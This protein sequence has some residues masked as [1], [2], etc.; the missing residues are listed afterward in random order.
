MSEPLSH[1]RNLVQLCRFRATD[2]PEWAQH[3]YLRDGEAVARVLTCAQ[4]DRAARALAVQLAR[5]VRPG[6]RAL[7]HYPP[8]LDFVIAFFGC[9]YAGVIAVPTAPVE[10][11]QRAAAARARAVVRSATPELLLSTNDFLAGNTDGLEVAAGAPLTRMAT[12]EVD[13][14]AAED[15]SAPSIEADTIAYLQYSSGSTGEPK[16]VVLTHGQVLHNLSVIVGLLRPRPADTRLVSWLPMFHDMGL[17]SGGL[18]PVYYGGRATLLAPATFIRRPHRWLAA[19][20]HDHVGELLGIARPAEAD[21]VISVVPNFAL[22]LC[23]RRVDE[24]R[25]AG[26]DL[27]PLRQLIIGAEQVRPHTLERFTAAF[28]PCGLRTEALQPCYGLAEATLLV[29]GGPAGEPPHVTEF[30]E[31]AARP[32]VGCG[33]VRP[34]LRVLIADPESLRPRAP[35]EVGE[36]LVSGPSVASGYWNAP[37]ATAG[38]FDAVPP[39]ETES[40]LRTGDLGTFVA[41]QL[42]VTGRRKDLIVIDGVNHYP[43]DLETTVEQAEP[44]VRAG[45]CAVVSVDDGGRELVVV[46]AELA[47]RE[48]ATVDD[49]VAAVRRALSARHGI[50]VHEVLL[51]RPG[52]LPFTSSGKLRRAECRAGYQDGR[53]ERCRVAP[54]GR[55]DDPAGG[56]RAAEVVRP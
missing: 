16:G 11:G 41:G 34:G 17:I 52:S 47:Q 27:R 55:G 21:D 46:L 32:L 49:P 5:R 48:E 35:G 10:G 1:I 29:S 13:P 8:G 54:P 51:L 37:A 42:F 43:A 45:R 4:L 19:I 33:E 12:D 39:G 28:G 50:A 14:A 56:R 31:P 26:L 44:A 3:A 9:L 40:F 7:L 22:E 20:G 25:R 53:F 2:T 18:L 6:A 24:R 36:I 38:T 15:W 30:A 23:V